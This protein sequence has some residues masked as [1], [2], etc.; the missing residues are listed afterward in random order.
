ML[1]VQPKLVHHGAVPRSDELLPHVRCVRKCQSR[2]TI[3][4]FNSKGDV[5]RQRIVNGV[6]TVV[7]STET[8]RD[9]CW[10]TGVVVAVRISR[11]C[12]EL[13]FSADGWANAMQLNDGLW[14]WKLRRGPGQA[15]TIVHRP[16]S[17][18]DVVWG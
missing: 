10:E 6:L 13:C 9:V 1:S 3:H 17:R 12:N 8:V 15:L 18:V 4:L 5:G 7:V 2:P 11:V 16:T 14:R